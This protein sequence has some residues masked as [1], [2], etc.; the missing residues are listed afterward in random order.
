MEINKLWVWGLFPAAE[1]NA[2]APE[3]VTCAVDDSPTPD[4]SLGPS[5]EQGQPPHPK[6]ACK[7]F[8]R[9]SLRKRE[10]CLLLGVLGKA[11]VLI[12]EEAVKE[13]DMFLHAFFKL[14]KFLL[15]LLAKVKTDSRKKRHD[16]QGLM[17]L[18]TSFSLRH[19]YLTFLFDTFLLSNV[20]LSKT[21]EVCSHPCWE[22]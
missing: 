1:S 4:C 21:F 5:A 3:W 20:L 17:D 14:I 6:E 22:L 8:Y 11:L 12:I 19:I 13:A 18:R 7:Y 16:F 9:S 2:N 10:L 15:P